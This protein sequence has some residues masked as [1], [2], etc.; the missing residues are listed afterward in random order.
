MAK[1]TRPQCGACK[2]STTG[3]C[4][5][6]KSARIAAEICPGSPLDLGI[7]R[8]VKVLRDAGVETFESCEGGEGHA[9]PEPTVRFHGG[10]GDGL[11]A[12]GVALNHRLPVLALRRTWPVYDG[13]PNGP[14]WELT[15][16]E[17]G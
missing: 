15:F 4:D 1:M 2:E 8:Y 14:Y 5:R 3:E 12:L 16:K 6:H 17:M 11:K 9:Y 7:A 13:G 10:Q